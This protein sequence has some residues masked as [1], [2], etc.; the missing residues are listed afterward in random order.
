MKP[1]TINVRKQ[2]SEL[3]VPGMFKGAVTSIIDGSNFIIDVRNMPDLIR[4]ELDGAESQR[5]TE[6]NVEAAREQVRNLENNAAEPEIQ[7]GDWLLTTDPTGKERWYRTK[8]GQYYCF[9]DGSSS[10]NIQVRMYVL[11][12]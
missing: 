3:Y 5:A 6:Q 10:V 1:F 9:K 7:E 12:D 8:K 2:I 11:I 4:Q